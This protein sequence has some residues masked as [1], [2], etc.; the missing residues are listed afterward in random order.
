[1][2]GAASEP[3]LSLTKKQKPLETIHFLAGNVLSKSACEI[4]LG[5]SIS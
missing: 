4:D 3:G 1:M 5:V 2:S